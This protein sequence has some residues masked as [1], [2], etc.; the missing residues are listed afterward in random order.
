MIDET[1]DEMLALAKVS[2]IE[3]RLARAHEVVKAD[4]ERAHGF[5]LAIEN[6]DNSAKRTASKLL[7]DVAK[8][9]SDI[10]DRLLPA[11]AQ[12]KAAA[13]AAKAA[14]TEAGKRRR[15]ERVRMLA[16]NMLTRAREVDEH[17]ASALQSLKAM[18]ADIDELR[19]LG[20][21]ISDALVGVN[22]AMA[23]DTA[24]MAWNPKRARIVP[25]DQRRTFGQLGEL[26]KTAALAH[27]DR[28]LGEEP[29]QDSQSAPLTAVSPAA[30]VTEPAPAEA[31]RAPATEAA[32]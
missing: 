6:G 17:L 3:A 11:L 1:A 23:V 10:V 22:M 16:P 25:P 19:A 13:A 18:R 29:A 2:E 14:A 24:D 30:A 27:A 26:W 31:A 12:A 4:R 8:L 5:A 15:A 32:A 20:V 28:A 9:E 7:A 21:P